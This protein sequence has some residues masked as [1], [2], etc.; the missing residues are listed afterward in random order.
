MV[1]KLCL[2]GGYF[3]SGGLVVLLD[4]KKP[5]SD[6]RTKVFRHAFV[7]LIASMALTLVVSVIVTI[8]DEGTAEKMEST[9]DRVARA[10]GV[11]NPERISDAVQAMKTTLV[12][13]ETTQ[14]AMHATL[15][16]VAETVGVAND[17]EIASA[18]QDLKNRSKAAEESLATANEK[19]RELES[20]TQ[21]LGRGITDSLDFNGARRTSSR[22]GHVSV[23]SG[24]PQTEAFARMSALEAKADWSG[25][26]AEATKA[27]RASPQWLT[28]M[29]FLGSAQARLGKTAEAKA[30]LTE[31]VR[32]SNGDPAYANAK[33]M[34]DAL[35]T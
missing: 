8:R 26:V 4:Y 23:V 21:Q 25:L 1:L 19:L 24:T 29:L 18:V 33:K 12:Q 10:V 15:R 31:V 34:L 35:G 28:P 16:K 5:W 17:E 13:T 20:K 22:P 2:L 14:E 3:V 32:L 11:D 30:T 6:K 27:R 7:A 9:V